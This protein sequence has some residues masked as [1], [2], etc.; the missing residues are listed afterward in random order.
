MKPILQYLG[1]TE[2]SSLFC[3]LFFICGPVPLV[4]NSCL[5]IGH[6]KKNKRLTL[7]LVLN[8]LLLRGRRPCLCPLLQLGRVYWES[9]QWVILKLSPHCAG[10]FLSLSRSTTQLLSQHL[11]WDLLCQSV[12]TTASRLALWYRSESKRTNLRNLHGLWHVLASWAL[13][14]WQGSGG[15]VCFLWT[16]CCNNLKICVWSVCFWIVDSVW[17]LTNL[18]SLFSTKSF[19]CQNSYIS[20]SR[21]HIQ[22]SAVLLW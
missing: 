18:L 1:V 5:F 10:C 9:D 21:R 17:A 2:F 6:G 13:S 20:T 11:T 19:R 16:G 8:K 7:N 15:F 14:S 4:E 3:D 12:C 22:C